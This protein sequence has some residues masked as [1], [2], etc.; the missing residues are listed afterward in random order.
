MYCTVQF[1]DYRDSSYCTTLYVKVLVTGYLS[2]EPITL[3]DPRGTRG[4]PVISFAEK[5]TPTNFLLQSVQ[6][7]YSTVLTKPFFD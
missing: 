2:P 3:D 6:Y 5:K 1:D 7:R 4:I